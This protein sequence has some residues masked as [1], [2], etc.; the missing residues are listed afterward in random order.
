MRSKSLVIL[1]MTIVILFTFQTVKAETF[2]VNTTKDTVDANPG[3][4]V[5]EDASGN[6]SLRAAIMEAKRVFA[7]ALVGPC[8]ISTSWK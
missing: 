6:T 5:A 2:M 1:Y 8:G 3:D 4:G 7:T